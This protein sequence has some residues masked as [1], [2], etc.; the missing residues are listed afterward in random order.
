MHEI[1][2]CPESGF[3]RCH[4]A[5]F[6]LP[7]PHSERIWPYKAVSPSDAGTVMKG[8]KHG[9]RLAR[10]WAQR[11]GAAGGLEPD[12]LLVLCPLNGTVFASQELIREGS[13]HELTKK[14]LQQR[15]FFL[16]RWL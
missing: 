8:L 14:G 12:C 2:L 7:A 16:V 1:S 4:Q 10:T 5:G 11:W 15:L 9:G 6:S 13:L 3:A